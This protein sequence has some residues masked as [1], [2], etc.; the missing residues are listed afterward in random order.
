[1]HVGSGPPIGLL[2][3]P[4]MIDDN[5]CGAGGGMGIGRG[6]RSK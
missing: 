5:E 4:R 1:V 2:Y 6:N 3:Q